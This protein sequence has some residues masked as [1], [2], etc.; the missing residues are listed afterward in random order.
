[1][2][3]LTL[4]VVGF[5][6]F[7]GWL[8]IEAGF[9]RHSFPGGKTGIVLQQAAADNHE[10]I[11]T[12]AGEQELQPQTAELANFSAAGGKAKTLT[13]GST[14]PKS[15]FK[16]LLELSSKGASVAKVTFSEFDDR[17]YKDPQ[18]L[19]VLSPVDRPRGREI[20]SM[21]TADFVFVQQRLKLAL[22][23][24]HWESFDFD[25]V[26]SYDG[27]RTARFEAT[28][29]NEDTGE[30][31]VKLVKTYTV[32]PGSYH[33]DCRLA[34]ENLSASEQKVQFELIGP[35]G[36]C[37]EDVRMDTRKVIGGF[38]TSAGQIVSSRKDIRASI[39]SK[40][41]GLKDAT[42]SYQQAQ[43][44]EDKE[45][46][47]RYLRI[48]YKQAAARFLWAATTNKYFAAILRPVPDKGRD[49]CDWVADKT[50]RFYNPDGDKRGDTGD[51]TI[52]VNLKIA[53]SAL[54]SAGQ[55][56]SAKTY[57]FLLYIGPKDKSLF[58]KNE[59][60]RKLGF[61]Q[62]IDFMGCC[63]PQSIIK[64]LA[65][66]IMA[67]MKWMY[68]FVRNYGVVIIILV[69]LMRL[70]MHPVTK[71]SQVSM[72]RMSKLAPKVE[73]I[74]K[75][76][77][78]S[79]TEMNKHIMALYK[80]QGA[81]PVMGMLPIM[82]QMPIWIA[83]W[84]A[85]NASI[86]LRGTAFLPV[87]ITDLS[88]PDALFR[89]SAITL[90]LLGKLDSFNLLPILMGVAF[91][92]QQ[93]LMPHQQAASTSPQIAKQQQMMMIMMPLMFPFVLYK[94]PSGV[95][96]YIMA[97]T[98]AGVLEQY[99]IRKH[100]REKEQAESKG[101]VEVTS[102]TGGKVKKKKPKPFYKM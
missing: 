63:C 2:R 22:D 3:I 41:L 27:S 69:F 35:V 61:F 29:E 40:N 16:F 6:V 20:L 91:Y 26:A 8:V 78:N 89:F 14:D 36:I 4:I 60:Y 10:A 39:L 70:A 32:Y 46:A 48:S 33:L 98:F 44:A 57:N 101:L 86:E 79:K 25:V 43:T 54:A 58:D 84:S 7:C 81:S 85:V 37:R 93:K 102:K 53:S 5:V 9:F 38:V 62:T 96:L 74:R 67:L 92:L 52:G 11:D 73:E 59:L 50:G 72:S 66:G 68:S 19:V 94:A 30:P 100:I 42:L 51:E 24:L 64:P 87:W 56:G 99:V 95:N 88:V 82:V 71:K 1:M 18:P 47:E 21:A 75:K 49:Y 65:F 90:P 17:D 45:Q 28:I 80:E 76:Y 13:L 31:V 83:L 12:P 15:G 55:A 34:V 97:S 23:R 77:A